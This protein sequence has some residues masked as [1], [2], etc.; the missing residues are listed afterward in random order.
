MIR[1]REFVVTAPLL[2]ELFVEEQ[3]LN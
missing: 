1:F 3:K 2:D